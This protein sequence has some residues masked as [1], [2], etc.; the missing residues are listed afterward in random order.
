MF[1]EKVIPID[2]WVS[3]FVEW[4]VDN[5]REIFQVAKWPIEQ[6]LTGFDNGLNAL[7]LV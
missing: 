4:L 7:H 1:E 5:H 2:E 6:T 3:R